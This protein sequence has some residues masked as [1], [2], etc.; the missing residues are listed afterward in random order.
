M[1]TLLLAFAVCLLVSCAAGPVYVAKSE[2][3]G[4]RTSYQDP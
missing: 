2:N 1:K 3:E 4:I